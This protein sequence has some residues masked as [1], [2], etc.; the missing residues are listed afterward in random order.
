MKKFEGGLFIV[1][2]GG[3][4]AGKTTVAKALEQIYR[5]KGY[6]VKYTREPG[7]IKEAEQ[8]R[9]IIV[10]ND[11]DS[12]TQ[13]MLF[14]AA[15]KLNTDRIITPALEEGYIVICDRYMLSSLVYQ[16]KLGAGTVEPVD[17]MKIQS[18]VARKPD[19]QI[20]L[21]VNPEIGLKRVFEG[22]REVNALD[23]MGLE[24]HNKVNR[25]YRCYCNDKANHI[26]TAHSSY[27][28][29]VNNL[30]AED[31]VNYC[32]L[33]IDKYIRLYRIQD[34]KEIDT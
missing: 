1:I 9:D 3:E 10:N 4:G 24:F 31:V 26:R 5:D 15:R 30:N 12:V 22:D 6:L 17:V 27:T 8:I 34:I 18:I 23:T 11:L 25:A 7:G 20:I 2:E 13:M 16:S 32:K 19:Y 28:I 29:D 14:A 33:L 21:D